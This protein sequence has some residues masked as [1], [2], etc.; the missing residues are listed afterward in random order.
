MRGMPR[1]FYNIT[2]GSTTFTRSGTMGFQ[3]YGSNTLQMSGSRFDWR[4]LH[5]A[6]MDRA[7]VD[8]SRL[9]ALKE[10]ARRISKRALDVLGA[11]FL[12]AVLSP[13]LVVVTLMIM[14]DG[15]KVLFGHRRIGAG[16]RQFKC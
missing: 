2:F 14:R 4:L 3:H 9:A 6:A 5:A 11:S 12:L 8:R 13:L 15:G 1:H 16:G 7:L 10:P